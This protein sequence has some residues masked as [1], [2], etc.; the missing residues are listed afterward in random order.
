CAERSSDHALR[1]DRAAARLQPGDRQDG[2]AADAGASARPDG[3]DGHA[4]GERLMPLSWVGPPNRFERDAP[5]TGSNSYVATPALV[6]EA[7]AFYDDEQFGVERPAQRAPDN[8]AITKETMDGDRTVLVL[9]W[10]STDAAVEVS[11]AMKNGVP[12]DVK[13]HP[14]MAQDA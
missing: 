11:Y 1:S 9:V 4:R 7:V 3:S 12:T 14:L 10:R 2:A 13:A 6:A 5:A 8:W